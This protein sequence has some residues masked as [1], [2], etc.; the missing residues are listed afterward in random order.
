MRIPSDTEIKQVK[1]LGLLHILYSV[2]VL[3]FSKSTEQIEDYNQKL[4]ANP[5]K[6]WPNVPSHFLITSQG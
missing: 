6:L 4:D 3:M 5:S 1:H 2:S